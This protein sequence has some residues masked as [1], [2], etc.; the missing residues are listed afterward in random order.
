MMTSQATTKSEWASNF[1][2][3]ACTDGWEQQELVSEQSLFVILV[4]VT[5]I[6]LM[7]TGKAV[8]VAL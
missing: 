7:S 5:L 3:Q 6:E 8:L 1:I 4:L 2:S